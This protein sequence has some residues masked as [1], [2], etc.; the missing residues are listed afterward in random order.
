MTELLPNVSESLLSPK[1]WNPSVLRSPNS[2]REACQDWYYARR[3]VRR[4]GRDLDVVPLMPTIPDEP[5]YDE[6]GRLL[7][8][9]TWDTLRARCDMSHMEMTPGF[10]V[11][12]AD[13]R[14]FPTKTS[15]FRTEKDREFDQF[16]ETTLHT[17]EPLVVL[18][19]TSDERWYYVVTETYHGFVEVDY[20]A[21]TTWS[22]FDTFAHPSRFA[23]VTKPS[24]LTQSQPYDV[25]VSNR[26]LEF[27]A[28][29]PLCDTPSTIGHQSSVGNVAVTLPI[30][31]GDGYLVTRPALVRRNAGI[32]I[33][34]L[35]FTRESLL[36]SAFALLFERYGW[37]GRL[38]SH[39][40]SS[41]VM[42][43]YRTVGIQ[44][45]RDAGVQANALPHPVKFDEGMSEGS[46]IELLQTLL[47]MDPLYMPGHTMLYLGCRCGHAYAIHDFAGYSSDGESFLVNEVMVST[48][49]I[50]TMRGTT[51]LESL[52]SGG[53]VVDVG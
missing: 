10:S 5:I 17:F 24:I 2:T 47:P 51:Y 39:D 7:D 30:R 18:G 27:A 48:L 41:F 34:W 43:V 50:R 32:H 21:L 12:P 23:V 26:Q 52:T 25:S 38:L 6:L 45:P 28:V 16:Q 53:S 13:V 1:Y 46:R 9:A 22:L 15:A 3:G 49:D 8:Q 36:E 19:V 20:V 42:D 31:D 44:I 29:L 4:L 35:P 14:R 11:C 33:G 37:G 40:C